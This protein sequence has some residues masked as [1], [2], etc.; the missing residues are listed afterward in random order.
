MTSTTNTSDSSGTAASTPSATVAKSSDSISPEAAA[1]LVAVI[2][3]TVVIAIVVVCFFQIQ[4]HWKIRHTEEA[5]AVKVD[6]GVEPR[7]LEEGVHL[8]LQNKAELS[9]EQTGSGMQAEEEIYEIMDR[10]QCRELP[11]EGFHQHMLSLEG[12]HELRGEDHA[13]ELDVSSDQQDRDKYSFEEPNFE[14]LNESV[15]TLHELA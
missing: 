1:V 15:L 5:E 3:P 11:D 9:V 14:K 10:D 2:V 13:R 8:Y 12:L 7:I 4:K 6:T